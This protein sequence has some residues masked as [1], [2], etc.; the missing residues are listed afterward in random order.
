MTVGGLIHNLT[1]FADFYE[2][3][4]ADIDR[5]EGVTKPQYI[6]NRD[7]N[8]DVMQRDFRA[9]V[10]IDRVRAYVLAKYGT[11]LTIGTARRLLGD[12]IRLCALTVKAA[13]E[14]TLEGAMDNLE[15]AES[16]RDN[17]DIYETNGARVGDEQKAVQSQTLR[18]PAQLL[19]AFARAAAQFPTSPRMLAFLNSARQDGL[20][21]VPSSFVPRKAD[22]QPVVV[23]ELNISGTSKTVF[24]H[25]ATFYGIGGARIA[26]ESGNLNVGFVLY[27]AGNDEA[28]T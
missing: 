23:G 7:A 24:G 17:A 8:A 6:G 28:V 18:T 20:V 22:G 14:L 19:E 10:A 1:V 9:T 4:S 25:N 16:R 5:E 26:S 27:G 13:E 11:D 21:T 2:Q 3:A 15:A 12:L